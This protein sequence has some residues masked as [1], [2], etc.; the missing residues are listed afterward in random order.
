MA[1]IEQLISLRLALE[2]S[3]NPRVSVCFMCFIVLF[4]MAILGPQ[5]HMYE[6][7]GH[8]VLRECCSRWSSESPTA[9]LLHSPCEGSQKLRPLTWLY[10][11]VYIHIYTCT[12]YVRM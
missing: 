11:C 6:Y 7:L 8:L 4:C 3:T 5:S 1:S 2:D 12:V 10:I 9:G